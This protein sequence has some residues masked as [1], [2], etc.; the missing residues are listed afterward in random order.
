MAF[1]VDFGS[2]YGCR[3]Y[4]WTGTVAEVIIPPAKRAG[5][6]VDFRGNAAPQEYVRLV[7]LRRDAFVGRVEMAWG[8]K[9]AR[10]VEGSPE[11]GDTVIG[12]QNLAKYERF[13]KIDTNFSTPRES[14][15]RAPD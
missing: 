12:I 9:A 13:R 11:A 6:A 7:V 14:S 2:K 4:S 1:G 3:P 15:A 5:V 10:I 8:G